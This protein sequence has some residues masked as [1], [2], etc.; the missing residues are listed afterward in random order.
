MFN[1]KIDPIIYS[2]VANIGGKGI[3]PKGIGTFSWS[4]T[5]GEGELHTKKFNNVLYFPD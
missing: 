5:D 4:W 3:I 1:D 2:A